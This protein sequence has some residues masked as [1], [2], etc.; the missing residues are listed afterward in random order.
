MQR[1]S[2]LRESPKLNETLKVTEDENDEKEIT[3]I[4]KIVEGQKG[5]DIHREGEREPCQNMYE[6]CYFSQIRVKL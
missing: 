2:M 1:E 6:D 3:T 5:R 4:K